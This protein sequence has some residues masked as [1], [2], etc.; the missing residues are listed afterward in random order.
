[1]R[2]ISNNAKNSN[3]EENVAADVVAYTIYCGTLARRKYI[4]RGPMNLWGRTIERAETFKI[5]LGP[6]LRSEKRGCRIF[7]RLAS[8]T[9]GA[10]R[11]FHCFSSRI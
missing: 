7:G 6:P 8:V 5:A 11:F 3:E 1:M 4:S 10:R 2:T 9:N